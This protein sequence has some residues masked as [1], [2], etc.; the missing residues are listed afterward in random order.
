MVALT[1]AVAVGF[2]FQSRAV[3]LYRE[4]FLRRCC[5]IMVLMHC[6]V[7]VLVRTIAMVLG[8]VTIGGLP[9]AARCEHERYYCGYYD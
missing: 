7:L 4:A 8:C 2:M 1:V 3:C 6:P 9:I 5:G